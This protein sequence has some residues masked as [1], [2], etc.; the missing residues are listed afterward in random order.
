MK[1][2]PGAPS[3]L[4]LVIYAR[5][6]YALVFADVGG[7]G[8]CCLPNVCQVLFLFHVRCYETLK[9]VR[10]QTSVLLTHIFAVRV[11][12]FFFLLLLFQQSWDA[13]MRV[14]NSSWWQQL[15]ALECF[16]CSFRWNWLQSPSILTMGVCLPFISTFKLPK[17]L[18][19]C[20]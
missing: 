7:G 19:G 6:S 14:L 4:L 10:S 11:A 13:D 16:L 3:V 5:V 15:W 12:F 9:E 18:F 20:V 1:D 2:A 17:K 8:S